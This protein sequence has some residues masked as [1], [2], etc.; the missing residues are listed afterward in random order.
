MGKARAFGSEWFPKLGRCGGYIRRPCLTRC[1]QASVIEMS[2][3]WTVK[4]SDSRCLSSVVASVNPEDGGRGRGT[5]KT[6]KNLK[7]FPAKYLFQ[8]K[9]YK[10]K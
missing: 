3:S 2:A 5:K 1:C 6:T 10:T 7:S 8:K 4:T 9:T